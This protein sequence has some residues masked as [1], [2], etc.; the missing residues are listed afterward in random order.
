MRDTE[1]YGQILGLMAPWHVDRV[2]LKVHDLCVEVFVEHDEGGRWACPECGGTLPVYDHAPVRRW[3]S[4]DTHHFAT[5]LQA[6]IPRVQCPTHGVRH[7]ACPWAEPHSRFTVLFQRFAIDVLQ[8]CSITGACRLLKISWDEAW[9]LMEQAVTRGQARKAQRLVPRIGV[10]EKAAAKG[11]K[12]LTLVCDLDH[13][14]IE[15]VGEDRKQESLDAY[16][17]ALTYEQRAAIEAVAMDMWE[18]Y[19]LATHARLPDAA[20]KIV[21]DRFHIMG[22]LG[23]AVDTVRKQEHRALQQ[24]GDDTLTGSKYLWL[25]S[26][27]NLPDHRRQEFAALKCQ[28]LKVSRA[29]A[30]KEH[31]RRLWAF[32]SEGW[33]TRFFKAWYWWATHSR[34]APIREVAALLKRHWTNI[35]TYCRHRI[36]NAVSESLNSRIEAIKKMAC[37]FRNP[38]HFKT[39]IYFHCGGLDLYPVIP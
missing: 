6:R 23:K 13:G 11:H 32:V 28:D 7:V 12:Y 8:E 25:Y 21:F 5:Y 2:E 26:R 37:G 3:R 27:E 39:A 10:D 38:E 15:Y 36:T 20:T 30:L 22:H 24:T 14:T 19:V 16:Y 29:W 1:L 34:L 35:V 18:P 4:L 9:H 31:L 17:Q 33:A